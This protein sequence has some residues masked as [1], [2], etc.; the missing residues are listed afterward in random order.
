MTNTIQIRQ[1]HLDFL[2]E[3]RIF[4]N[5]QGTYT[6]SWL[7]VGGQYRLVAGTAIESYAAQYV[8]PVFSSIGAFGYTKS[9]FP[10]NVKIG[11][12]CAIAAKVSVMPADH[13][14]DR[15]STCGFDYSDLPIFTSYEKDAGIAFPKTK[16]MQK[17]GQ[18]IIGND[19][20]IAHEVMIKRGVT[21]G[22]GAIVGAGSIVTRD[23]P[24]YAI[25]AGSPAVVRRYRFDDNTIERLLKS[26]WWEYGY[27]DF[28]NLKT[29]EVSNFL[30]QFEELV[31]AGKIRPLVLPIYDIAAEF[32]AISERLEATVS[33]DV[34]LSSPAIPDS[35]PR[36]NSD[37]LG[38]I[39]AL[40][41]QSI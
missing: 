5:S 3:K 24:S 32:R 38:T 40:T 28:V 6:P 37:L 36:L 31:G 19:V 14:M 41:Q 25:V 9:Y 18:P 27:A 33:Q 20:W 11:R 8:G 30:D 35:T 39:P 23:V 1:E 10:P 13:P 34:A 12:Y 2:A 22:T 15:L 21:I 17:S 7:K 4:L 16:A 29:L 26:K